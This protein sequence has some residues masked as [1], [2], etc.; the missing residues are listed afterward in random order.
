LRHNLEK[1]ALARAIPT[2]DSEN[3]PFLEVEAHVVEG[4]EPI[5]KAARLAL[6]T[7]REKRI[8]LSAKPGHH[9][10]TS[11]QSI[12]PPIAPRR[13]SLLRCSTKISVGTGQTLYRVHEDPLDV[14]EEHQPERE[15]HK[16]A[17]EA[18]DEMLRV[19]CAYPEKPSRK[20]SMNG[21]E[22]IELR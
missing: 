14:S 4:P 8:G 6:V 13:Y 3:L 2:D 18:C 22:W 12:P 1:R 21:C 15:Q 16:H 19:H 10:E 17:R 7:D 20:P 11:C 5:P 9:R